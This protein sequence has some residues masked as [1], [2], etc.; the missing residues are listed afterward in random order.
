[1]K[2]LISLT[3]I[4]A[5]VL[6]T[7][8][9]C[10][11]GDN[12]PFSLLSRTARI[13]GEWELIGADYLKTYDGGYSE[14]FNFNDT[15]MTITFSDGDSEM[16]TYNE[17]VIINKDGTYTIEKEEYHSN[18]FNSA[19]IFEGLWYFLDGVDGLDV[20]NK[21][22]VE[23]ITLKETWSFSFEGSSLS[24]NGYTEYDGASNSNIQI[25]LLDRLANNELIILFDYEER[26]D[27]GDFY[28]KK[29][30]MTYSKE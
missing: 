2:K 20:K 12:D 15:S 21:E 28:Q 3:I 24:E 16:Y 19:W 9:G 4:S 6:S 22:R 27:D 25:L 11:K 8:V 7:F 17:S 18:G 13:T 23:F 14:G 1:M 29:G 10:K 5:L 26:D 30:T